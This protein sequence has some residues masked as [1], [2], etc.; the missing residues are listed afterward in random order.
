MGF[1]EELQSRIVMVTVISLQHNMNATDWATNHQDTAYFKLQTN[2][3]CEHIERRNGHHDQGNFSFWRQNVKLHWLC[4]EGS[5][6][7]EV[8]RG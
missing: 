1:P 2:H 6:A 5:E 4:G 7:M 8:V 3:Q